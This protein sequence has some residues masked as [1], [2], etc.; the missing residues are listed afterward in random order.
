MPGCRAGSAHRRA[1]EEGGVHPGVTPLIEARDVRVHFGTARAVDGVSI[2]V[3]PGEVVALVGESGSGK[4]TLIR[5]LQGLQPVTSGEIRIRGAEPEWK[6]RAGRRTF[7]DT[8]I[9][10]VF[11][12][13]TGELK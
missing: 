8:G 13:P 5:A 2:S 4:T 11:Q 7:H 9:Q 12:D 3:L 10:M 1:R 6:G